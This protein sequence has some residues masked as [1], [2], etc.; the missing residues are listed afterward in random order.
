MDGWLKGDPSPQLAITDPQITYYHAVVEGR[1]EGLAAVKD[2]YERFRGMPLFESYEILSPK[3]Q[4][5]GDVAILSY[6]LAQHTGEGTS[7]WNGTQV[8][9]LKKEGWRVIHTHWSAAKAQQP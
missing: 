5:A 7:F 6:R 8:Y 4:V 1:L 9:Q 2:L 3:V